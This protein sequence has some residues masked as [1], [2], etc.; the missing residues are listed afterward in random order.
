MAGKH[1]GPKETWTRANPIPPSA[2]PIVMTEKIAV[3]QTPYGIVIF[4]AD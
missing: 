1:L 2:E 4:A 3:E